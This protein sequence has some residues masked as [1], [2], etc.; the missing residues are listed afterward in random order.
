MDADRFDAL[1]RSLIAAGSRRHTLALALSGALA[2]LLAR[3]DAAAHDPLKTCTK[4]SGKQKKKC[5]KKAKQHNA[6][7]RIPPPAPLL[8]PPPLSCRQLCSDDC[9]FCYTRADGSH[10]CGNGSG[11]PCA[12]ACTSD[13]DCIGLDEP[14]AS[15]AARIGRRGKSPF[16]AARRWRAPKWSGTRPAERIDDRGASESEVRNGLIPSPGAISHTR[17]HASASSSVLPEKVCSCG[18]CSATPQPAW[19]TVQEQEP[20]RVVRH[21]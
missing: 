17:H 14:I 8:P 9:T 7:H 11:S 19:S 4:K 15:G 5:I 10:L 6:T 3:D 16:P 13:T 1:S 20:R 12:V 2:S 18:E 21:R